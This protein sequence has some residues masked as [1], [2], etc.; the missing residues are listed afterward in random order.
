MYLDDWPDA[1]PRPGNRALESARSHS[2]W[3]QIYRLDPATFAIL[4]PHHR[5]EV[6]SYLILGEERAI[7]LDT[8]M[9]IADIAAE[10]AA[11]T[12]LPVF[13]VNTHGHYD[14]VGGDHRFREIWSLDNDWEVARIQRGLSHEEAAFILA[15]GQH[16]VLPE[17]F[18]PAHYHIQPAHVTYRLRHGERI[19]LGGRTLE[20]WATPG[21]S[22]GSLCLFEEKSGRLF[23]GDTVYPGLLYAQLRESN[24][25]QYLDS[26]RLLADRSSAVR[27]VSSAHH[28]AQ[29]GPALLPAALTAVEQIHAGQATA[30]EQRGDFLIYRFDEIGVITRAG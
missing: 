22:P 20:V 6:I 9:G 24:L 25:A 29:V 4:E 8:G 18:D 14:H 10:V 3:F 2:A 12:R 23:S 17:G 16:Q 7:L 5:E 30:A 21:H 26:L 1:L 19:D 15:P 13:V 28:E 11:L 27:W